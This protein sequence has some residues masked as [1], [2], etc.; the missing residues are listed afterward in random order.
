MNSFISKIKTILHRKKKKEMGENR[1]DRAG[2]Q[3][4]QEKNEEMES[5]EGLLLESKAKQLI[6]AYLAGQLDADAFREAFDLL[7]QACTRMTR[8]NEQDEIVVTASLPMNLIRFLGY[9]RPWSQLETVRKAHPEKFTPEMIDRYSRDFK[10][11]CSQYWR[12]L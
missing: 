11:W 12:I 3:E 4:K 6:G 2:I 1:E 8:P 9:Y 5:N 10:N 7:D